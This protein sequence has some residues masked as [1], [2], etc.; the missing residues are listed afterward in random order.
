MYFNHAYQK[1]LIATDIHGTPGPVGIYKTTGTPVA[2]FA[3]PE[4]C[5]TV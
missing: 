2:T 3:K 4:A 5:A 1:T